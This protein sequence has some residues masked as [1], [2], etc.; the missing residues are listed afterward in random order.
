MTLILTTLCKNGIC[1]CADTRYH[2]KSGSGTIK[3]R[4]DNNKIYKFVNSDISLIIFNHG[5]N[6]INSKNWE[7]FCPDYIK[8]NRWKDKDIK[9]VA[10]NFKLFIEED[11]QKELQRN[12][13]A[14]TIGF[15]IC[16]KTIHDRDFDAHELWWNPNYSFLP[17]KNEAII[18]TGGGKTC[19]DDHFKNHR[20]LNTKE[21]WESK[22]TTDAK[23]ELEKLFDIAI[24]ERDRLSRND[25]SDDYN[26]ECIN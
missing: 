7:S 2:L 24:E 6:N 26:V 3:N 11:I 16:G 9:D 25:F 23:K 19:L 8:S 17:L 13:Q 12:K 18:K 22:N 20:E 14:H 15:V 5:I 4:D 10:K 21:F 1:T